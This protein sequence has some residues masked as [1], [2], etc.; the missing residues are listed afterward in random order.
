MGIRLF[1]LIVYTII[2]RQYTVL[3]CQSIHI[4]KESNSWDYFLLT[5]SFK[6]T[7]KNNALHAS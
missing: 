6:P 5:L 1:L 7:N 4:K 3:H 2:M